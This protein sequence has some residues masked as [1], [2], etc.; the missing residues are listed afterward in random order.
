MVYVISFL[1]FVCFFVLCGIGYIIAKKPL[2]GSCGGVAT[3]MGDESCQFCG[4]D[5]HK[6]E[7][8]NAELGR[9]VG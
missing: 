7:E 3:L 5:P 2:K 8:V 6:C 4:G 9:K 1:I